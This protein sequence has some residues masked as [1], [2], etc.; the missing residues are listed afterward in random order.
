MKDWA[1]YYA[2][3]LGWRMFPV[4]GKKPLVSHWK[5]DATADPAKIEALAAKHPN[6]GWAW[7]IGPGWVVIDLDGAEGCAT[8]GKMLEEH[9]PVETWIAE[10]G[11]GGLHYYFRLPG[12]AKVRN[13]VGKL[14]PGVDVKTEGGYVVV[15]PSPHPSGK[16]YRWRGEARPGKCEV[17]DAPVWLLAELEKIQEEHSVE[18]STAR[19]PEEIIREGQRNA[20]LASLA[21]SMRRRGLDAE[22][23]EAALLAHNRKYCQPPLPDAEV[24]AIATSISRYPPAEA[25]AA[26]RA[27]AKQTGRPPGRP[28]KAESDTKRQYV[29]CPRE[30]KINEVTAYMGENVYYDI[31]VEYRG[32]RAVLRVDSFEEYISPR[33]MMA[34][35]ARRFCVPP[36]ELWDASRTAFGRYMT[37]L[38]ETAKQV[39]QEDDTRREASVDVEVLRLLETLTP[40]RPGKPTKKET[41]MVQPRVIIGNRDCIYFPA[42][43]RQLLHTAPG[44]IERQEVR[45]ALKRLGYQSTPVTFGGFQ[46]RYWVKEL[47]EE[48]ENRETADSNIRATGDREDCDA[49]GVAERGGGSR[50]AAGGNSCF[51]FFEVGEGGDV[52]PAEYGGG[53]DTRE[54]DSLGWP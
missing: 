51:K 28:K 34:L 15:P 23:I 1:V 16:R 22:A 42:F 33:A 49:V 52:E 35:F 47:E 17:A 14:G 53:E 41:L 25:V 20:K 18:S 12:G 38:L 36:Q 3:A 27:L 32:E 10:T 44:K 2:K 19:A 7:A 31:E 11:G 5:D 46:L 13:S 40:Y 9:G 43:Y 26:A 30:Y 45:D 50:G 24:R 8:W 48:D 4:A 54:D 21:G 39:R 6:A 37:G 29:Y